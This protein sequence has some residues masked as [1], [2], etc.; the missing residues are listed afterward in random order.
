L[1]EEWPHEGKQRLLQKELLSDKIPKQLHGCPLCVSIIDTPQALVVLN[2]TGHIHSGVDVQ[3]IQQLAQAANATIMYQT[4]PSGDAVKDRLKS[5][6]NLEKGRADPTISHL[7]DVM[8]WY[9]PCD[10]PNDRMGRVMTVFTPSL[11]CI[12]VSS[13]TYMGGG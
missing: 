6:A 3:Y 8:I 13:C 2:N 4:A 1:V 5:I 9:V 11:W 12:C 10:V 7:D